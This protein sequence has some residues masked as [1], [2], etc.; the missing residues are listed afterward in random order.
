MKNS[1]KI[2]YLY[3][4]IMGY[5][6]S[7]IKYL[8][9]S[10][11]K[12]SLVHWDHKKLSNYKIESLPNLKIYKRSEMT[13]EDIT[14]LVIELK[15]DI[16]VVAGWFDK[17]YLFATKYLRKKNKVV[18]CQLDSQWESSIKNPIKKLI[19]NLNIPSL[20]FSHYWIPGIPQYNFLKKLNIKDSKII[21]DAL[22]ADTIFFQKIYNDNILKKEISYPHKFFYAGR[23]DWNKGIKE[24]LEAWNKINSIKTDWTLKIIGDDKQQK[25]FEGINNIEI[26]DYI[27][28]SEYSDALKDVGCF[29]LPSTWEPWGVVVHEFCTAGIPIILSDKVGA[30][31]DY[32]IQGYNGY[33][34]KAGNSESLF[35][36]MLKIINSNDKSLYQMAKNSN[37]ISKKVTIDSS[38]AN[39]LS[40]LE[41]NN[42]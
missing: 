15:P 24:L 5:N 32:L 8:I 42:I 7:T 27:Q 3:S 33:E 23:I 12:V 21:F 11:A 34:F 35:N 30:K 40:S 39:L 19:F 4:E 37:S 16:T 18:V 38:V 36:S 28:P 9:K 41:S 10:G 31:D 14:N 6:L 2:L 22:S 26:I 13:K 20:F 1:T 25:L 17:G 29:V